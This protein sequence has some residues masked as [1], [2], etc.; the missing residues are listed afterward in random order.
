[1][2]KVNLDSHLPRE[3]FEVTGNSHSGNLMH[4]IS[5]SDLTGGFFYPFMRKPDFFALRIN[6]NT[7]KTQRKVNFFII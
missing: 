5:I 2:A 1:M 3:D 4:T 6:G 7:I